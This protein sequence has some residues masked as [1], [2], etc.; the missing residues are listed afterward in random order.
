MKKLLV[1]LSILMLGCY[2]V[3]IRNP[4]TVIVESNTLWEGKIDT[5]TVSGLFD[6]AFA[7]NQ[8]LCWTFTKKTAEGY[9]IAFG[10]VENFEYDKGHPTYSNDTTFAPFGTVRGC[11]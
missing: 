1:V 5:F 3:L 11:H 4:R 2:Q 6:K 8:K 7:T 10:S 9:L